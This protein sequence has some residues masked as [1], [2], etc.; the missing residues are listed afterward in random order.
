MKNYKVIDGFIGDM[1]KSIIPNK[2][3]V[4]VRLSDDRLGQTLSLSAYNVLI[5]IPLEPIK[6]IVVV[7]DD[8]WNKLFNYLN[9][10]RLAIAPDERVTDPEELSQR[11]AQTD[12][13]DCIMEE[14]IRLEKK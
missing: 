10:T 13:L 6:D 12:I 7:A 14:M 11:L 3:K 5:G 8:K 1:S 2:C 9:D 4:T